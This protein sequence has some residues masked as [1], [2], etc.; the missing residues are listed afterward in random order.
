MAKLARSGTPGNDTENLATLEWML[1]G[2]GGFD[3]SAGDGLDTIVGSSLHDILRGEE[4]DDVLDGGVGDDV[5]IGNAG[6]D[7]LLNGEVVF[8]E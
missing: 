7:V 6:D 8:D 1:V 5:L 4:G 2:Y 3:Y